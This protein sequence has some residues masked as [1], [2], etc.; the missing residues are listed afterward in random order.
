VVLHEDLTISSGATLTIEEGATIKFKDYTKLVV[1]GVLD[2]NGTSEDPITLTHVDGQQK[3]Y[4]IELSGSGA[5]NSS[6]D[7]CVIEKALT[8]GSSALRILN[9]SPTIQ[10]C[11]ISGNV[12][13]GTSGIYVYNGNPKLYENVI[14]NNGSRGIYMNNSGGYIYHNTIAGNNSAGVYCYNSSGPYFGK[15]GTYPGENNDIHN[16]HYGAYVTGSSPVIGTQNNAYYRNT[17]LYSNTVYNC[18]AVNSSTV[19]AEYVWWGS[20]PPQKIEDD[21]T[22]SIDYSPWLNSSPLSKEYPSPLWQVISLRSEGKY[23]EAVELCKKIITD[24]P[25]SSDAVCAL[26]ELYLIYRECRIQKLLPTVRK[27]PIPIRT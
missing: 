21:A 6:L 9:C 17:S 25:Y 18:Y 1:N 11:T 27:Y 16:N 7:Y 22:S 4:G 13:Y 5:N 10:N 20:D 23:S 15:P 26:R 24:D 19:L 8:Y 14:N 2:A 12:N 3:W